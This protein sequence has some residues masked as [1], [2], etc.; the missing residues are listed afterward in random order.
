MSKR[1]TKKQRDLYREAAHPWTDEAQKT[2]DVGLQVLELREIRLM[3][4]AVYRLSKVLTKGEAEDCA[5]L[6]S[7]LK[8]IGWP[9]EQNDPF[10]K[11]PQPLDQAASGDWALTEGGER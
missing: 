11:A 1:I 3:A 7:K 10:A 9:D 2:L 5:V 6:F 4:L 8:P